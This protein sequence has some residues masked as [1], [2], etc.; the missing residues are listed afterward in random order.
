[1]EPKTPSEF[2]YLPLEAPKEQIRLCRIVKHAPS[3]IHCLLEHYDFKACPPYAALSYTWG[4]EQPVHRIKMNEGVFEVRQNL[5]DF[6]NSTAVKNEEYWWIDQICIDQSNLQ[7]RSSQVSVM[8]DIYSTAKEVSVWLGKASEDSHLV[9]EYLTRLAE[10]ARWQRE[11][12]ALTKEE[13]TQRKPELRRDELIAL[14]KLFCRPYWSRVWVCQELFLAKHLLLCCGNQSYPEFTISTDMPCW[15]QLTYQV[16]DCWSSNEF[17]PGSFNYITWGRG[18]DTLYVSRTLNTTPRKN[19]S[20]AF[21]YFGRRQCTDWHDHVYGLMGMVKPEQAVECDYTVSANKLFLQ[22]ALQLARWQDRKEDSNIQLL[23]IQ[24]KNLRDALGLGP[25]LVDFLE[26]EI[27]ITEPAAQLPA[28]DVL[29]IY[30]ELVDSLMQKN[31]IT[32]PAAELPK[33]EMNNAE[34]S[35]GKHKPYDEWLHDDNELAKRWYRFLLV[36]S[37]V[38]RPH[39]DDGSTDDEGS[40]DDRTAMER[41]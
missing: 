3:S 41:R 30:P 22:T 25:E 2:T 15:H 13:K 35:G 6:L 32:W 27:G 37:H 38:P 40:D 23:S 18:F 17:E 33:T 16:Y 4:P 8:G 29:G 12:E 26:Q 31:G 36:L 20:M 34:H 1:M 39:T 24:Y 14:Y 7:E 9:F 19:L 28:M 11:N 10:W 21:T 5:F